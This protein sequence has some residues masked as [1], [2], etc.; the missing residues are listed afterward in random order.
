MGSHVVDINGL[1]DKYY[2]GQDELRKLIWLHSKQVTRKALRIVHNLH[3]PADHEFVYC[4]AFLH[5][6]GVVKCEA[7]SIHAFGSLPYICHGV[8][9]RK[10]LEA[11]GLPRLA[12]VCERHTGSGITKQQIIKENLP[13]PQRDMLPLTLEEKLICY[14]DK[15]FSK[16]QDLTREKSVEEIVREM[17]RFG[18]QAVERFLAL[19]KEFGNHK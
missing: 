7:P 13:L 6:I 10:I 4:G 5:D 11:N 18:P 8:E 19:D 9:G 17:E 16:S 15:F 1:F 3:L 12:L 2:E 14:A